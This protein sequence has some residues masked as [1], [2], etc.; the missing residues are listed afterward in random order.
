VSTYIAP[1]IK[2]ALVILY[3]V[4]ISFDI[5]HVTSKELKHSRPVYETMHVVER[6]LASQ[7]PSVGL[8][9]FGFDW[10]MHPKT[11][12]SD[13]IVSAPLM[14]E[15]C[16]STTFEGST[17]KDEICAPSYWQRTDFCPE[18]KG[19]ALSTMTT[20]L[21]TYTNTLGSDKTDVNTAIQKL[22]NPENHDGMHGI[23]NVCVCMGKTAQAAGTPTLAWANPTQSDNCRMQQL[24]YHHTVLNDDATWSLM[25]AH[26]PHVLRFGLLLIMFLA[27]T[28]RLFDDYSVLHI[29]TVGIGDVL[30][31]YRSFIK[32]GIIALTYIFLLAHRMQFALEDY[33]TE[34][35]GTHIPMERI[36]PNGSYFY[37]LIALT[38][39]SVFAVSHEKDRAEDPS[40]SFDP[41]L[42]S[43]LTEL[44]PIVPAVEVNK[45]LDVSKFST[46]AKKVNAYVHAGA[47][48]GT[49]AN[50]DAPEAVPTYKKWAML[51]IFVWPLIFLTTVTLD[52]RYGIDVHLELI[53]IVAV[54]Y[55]VLDWALR[56]VFEG[57]RLYAAV[58]QGDDTA[59]SMIHTLFG[60]FF[61]SFHFTVAVIVFGYL[62]YHTDK[63]SFMNVFDELRET[64]DPAIEKVEHFYHYGSTHMLFLVY[65]IIAFVFKLISTSRMF[66]IM[67]VTKSY[68]DQILQYLGK[69][70]TYMDFLLNVFV[71]IF[72]FWIA[73]N[74]AKDA[75]PFAVSQFIIPSASP[76]ARDKL[77]QTT[78]YTWSAG[79]SHFSSFPA[80]NH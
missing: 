25:G 26:S 61:T 40:N 68:T 41:S 50:Y 56:R 54:V 16:K 65:I 10:Y 51:Q 27:T 52:M 78:M 74:P 45:N 20:A 13:D 35:N 36:V 63:S 19:T 15:L 42:Q 44:K 1:L 58:I 48:N 22:W 30:K 69:W 11:V 77:L 72:V 57:F 32:I 17:A 24:G 46:R 37:V 9:Y 5:N 38:W 47:T 66:K 23:E 53:F 18:K 4:L 12:H 8:S 33:K 31:D 14:P 28:T 21:T 75:E 7:M 70:D 67:D 80:A 79:W 2:L 29:Q 59:L 55:G 6:N 3:L 43:E 73:F 49:T 62:N 39:Y 71:L 60:A 34:E 76:T 64:Q